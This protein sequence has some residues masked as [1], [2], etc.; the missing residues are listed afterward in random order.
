LQCRDGGF[1][2]ILRFPQ[3][4]KLTDIDITEIVLKVSLNTITSLIFI[5]Q[6]FDLVGQLDNIVFRGIYK[7]LWISMRLLILIEY[8]HISFCKYLTT[9]EEP[10]IFLVCFKLYIFIL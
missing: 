1:L 9:E 5:L 7:W 4:I 3:P 2:Q 10:Y 6:C 8:Q